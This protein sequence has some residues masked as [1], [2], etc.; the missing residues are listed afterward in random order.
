MAAGRSTAQIAD[1]IYEECSADYGTTR[2]KSQRL[3]H[4][5]ALADVIEQVRAL[6]ARD[7]KSQPGMGETLLS[8]Y[9]SGLKRPGPEYL[10]YLCSVYRVEPANLGYDGPCICGH[11][12]RMPG[13]MRGDSDGNVT[14]IDLRNSHRELYIQP[15]GPDPG[16]A[17]NE[18]D[19]N[20]LRTSLLTVLTNPA[21]VQ[22]EL[23][24]PVLGAIENIRRRM[25]ETL[26]SATVSPAMLD[27]WEEALAGFGRQYMNTPPLRLLCD[28]MLEFS[29]VRK[30]MD[31]RQ[32]IDLQDR[33]CH[34]AAQLAGLGGMIMIN[35][36]DHRLARAFFRTGRT[37]AD[38]TGNRA[39]RAWVCARE[40]LVPLYL[41]DPREAL[42]LAKKSRDL[43]GQTPC[44][45]Q[46]MAPVVEARALAM[47]SG[48]GRKDVVDQ[49]KRALSRARAAFAQMSANEKDDATFGY[50]ERQ[51]YFHQ[52]DALVKLGQ[53]L[54]A[55]LVLEQA[56]T[57]YG[58]S[59]WLDPV[60]IRF[61]RAKCK[62]LEG[63]LDEAMEIGYKLLSELEASYRADIV[64]KRADELAKAVAAKNPRHPLLEPYRELLK[65]P[66]PE[67]SL[68]NLDTTVALAT[69][70]SGRKSSRSDK[71]NSAAAEA[72]EKLRLASEREA[73]SP[74]PPAT[75]TPAAAPT[76]SPDPTDTA[77]PESMTGPGE[78]DGSDD[79]GPLASVTPI[80]SIT[81]PRTGQEG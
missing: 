52:G 55:D 50:T 7:G 57:K 81:S 12:H 56:L 73:A 9:E 40:A 66:N 36:G 63:D 32:P 70:S 21:T 11:G 27:Q 30:A 44:A 78:A 67:A 18:E 10:H 47:L 3:A 49:A 58:P 53:A 29:A 28:V 4:G 39:L 19:E 16:S 2:I 43:A 77:S 62:V 74:Q 15:A 71:D 13:V 68:A 14:R 64:I 25:D 20:I 6:F 41:G 80:T 17:A 69:V 23:A 33:L 35:L 72:L 8:S 22:A 65:K 59:E 51:L 61:D 46:A 26:V 60:L 31:R 37:A 42:N 1:M 76:P 45:A 34:M 5:I 79:S 54:E 48:S 38:E 24:A 75:A